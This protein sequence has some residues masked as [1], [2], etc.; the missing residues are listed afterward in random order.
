MSA[1][2]MQR[3]I[4]MEEE[5]KWSQWNWLSMMSLQEEVQNYRENDQ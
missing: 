4:P 3:R 2:I 5:A 1:W